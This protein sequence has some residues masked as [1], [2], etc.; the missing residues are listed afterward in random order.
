MDYG[1][2]IYI[3]SGNDSVDEEF[4]TDDILDIAIDTIQADSLHQ[5][6]VFLIKGLNDGTLSD[7]DYYFLYDESEMTLLSDLPIGFVN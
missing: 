2:R 6:L 1:F 4:T 7:E 5:M 3:V